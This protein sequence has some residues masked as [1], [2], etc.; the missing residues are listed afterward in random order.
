MPVDGDAQRRESTRMDET[1]A[2]PGNDGS[3]IG[4]ARVHGAEEEK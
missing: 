4:L 3:D 2:G 1:E